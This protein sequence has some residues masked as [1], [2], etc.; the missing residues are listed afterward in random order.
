MFLYVT[1]LNFSNPWENGAKFTNPTTFSGSN[2]SAVTHSD[3]DRSELERGIISLCET[4]EPQKSLK[5][6]EE[7]QP[8][9]DQE[10][11]A[12]AHGDSTQIHCGL[13]KSEGK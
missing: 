4:K 10:T 2:C 9:H 3:R 7:L 6:I 8:D 1:H 12:L 13:H 11:L 5:L